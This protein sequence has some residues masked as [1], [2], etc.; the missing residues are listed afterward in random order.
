MFAP[1]YYTIFKIKKQVFSSGNFK[2]SIYLYDRQFGAVE[3]TWNEY[4]SHR[5]CKASADYMCC[6][7]I[8][9]LTACIFGENTLIGGIKSLIQNFRQSPLTAVSVS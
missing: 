4:H 7:V 6:A 9:I 8:G 3:D 1:Y 2:L 5:S